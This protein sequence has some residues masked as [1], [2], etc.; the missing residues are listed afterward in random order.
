MLEEQSDSQ[1]QGNIE[2][3]AQTES[4]DSG[5]DYKE[6]YNQ[7]K[8]YSQKQRQRARKAE[9]ELEKVN[10]R[11]KKMEEDSLIEQNKYEELWEND[12]ADAEENRSYKKNRRA[13]LLDSLPEDKRDK[14]KNLDLISLEAVVEELATNTNKEPMKAV[15]GQVSTPPLNKAYKDMTDAE[16]RQWHNQVVESKN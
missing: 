6:S 7:E 16:K 14:F 10:A 15:P 2:Q 4:L 12:K 1:S 13:K 11:N 5:Q 9:A 8:V 3:D